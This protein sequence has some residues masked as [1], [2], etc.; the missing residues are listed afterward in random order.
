MRTNNYRVD[1]ILEVTFKDNHDPI[2]KK[3]KIEKSL[4]ILINKMELKPLPRLK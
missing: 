3:A 2:L 1:K 4:K